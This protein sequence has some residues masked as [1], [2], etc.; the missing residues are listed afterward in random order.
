MSQLDR[1]YLKSSPE[2]IVKVNV[3]SMV[4]L[5][6]VPTVD[7]EDETFESSLVYITINDEEKCRLW[8]GTPLM[9]NRLHFLH[10]AAGDSVWACTRDHALV[11]IQIDSQN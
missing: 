6:V 1:F 9:T 5:W 10:L 4:T 2:V 8:K 7:M 11:G 3:P